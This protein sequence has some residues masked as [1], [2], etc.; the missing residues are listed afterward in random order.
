MLLNILCLLTNKEYGKK[1]DK[2]SINHYIIILPT[3]FVIEPILF[4]K[5]NK[6]L[7]FKTQ[8]NEIILLNTH[9]NENCGDKV[10][11]VHQGF[12]CLC[13][14]HNE[15]L[16]VSGLHSFKYVIFVIFTAF[17]DYTLICVSYFFCYIVWLKV[18]CLFHFIFRGSYLLS[19][20]SFL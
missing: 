2:V 6:F 19:H 17:P 3:R 11:F 12:H 20:L 5:I 8:K 16:G 9:N 14:A 4:C 15:N 7:N 10:G 18:G 13:Y 1:D